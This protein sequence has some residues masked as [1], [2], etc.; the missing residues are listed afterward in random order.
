MSTLAFQAGF[1]ETNPAFFFY[2]YLCLLKTT[3]YKITQFHTQLEVMLEKLK[4]RLP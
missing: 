3:Y 2:C 1:A 4:L